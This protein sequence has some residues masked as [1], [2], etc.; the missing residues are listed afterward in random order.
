VEENRL[1]SHLRQLKAD[2]GPMSWKD[3]MDHLWTYYKWVAGLFILLLVFL[4]I[5]V[6]AM[7]SAKTEI[8]LSGVGINIPVSEE[9][10]ACLSSEYLL[11]LE[12]HKRQ[13]VQYMNEVLDFDNPVLGQETSYSTVVKVSGLYTTGSLDYLL[14]DQKALDYYSTGDLFMDLNNLFSEEELAQL[15]ISE[16]GGVPMLMDLTGTWFA[17]TYIADDGPYYLAF[18]QTTERTEACY[19]FWQYLATGK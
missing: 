10:I 5:G 16:I 4:N 15:S 17:D 2:L 19:N 3:R 6:T 18:A 9:G 14:L 13:T 12:G 8:L 7:I 1:K 11:R